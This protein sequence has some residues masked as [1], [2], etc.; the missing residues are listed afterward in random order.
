MVM[1]ETFRQTFPRPVRGLHPERYSINIT[2][3]H[4]RCFVQKRTKDHG[5]LRK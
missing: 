2:Y 1:E 3:P 4:D 5:S